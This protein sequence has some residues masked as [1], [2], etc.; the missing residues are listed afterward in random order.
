MEIPRWPWLRRPHR[1][2]TRKE[3]V[4][5]DPGR[6]WVIERGDWKGMRCLRQKNFQ[7]SKACEILR[8]GEKIIQ[9]PK[10]QKG[11]GLGQ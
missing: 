2:T 11:G 7:S 6:D 8:V 10:T 9:K 5:E 1:E 3:G 4:V